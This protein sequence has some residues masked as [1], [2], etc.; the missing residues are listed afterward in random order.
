MTN[1]VD[2]TSEVDM[3]NLEMTGDIDI[4][5]TKGKDIPMIEFKETEDVKIENLIILKTIGSGNL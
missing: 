1:Y 3:K 4:E 2:F 5:E